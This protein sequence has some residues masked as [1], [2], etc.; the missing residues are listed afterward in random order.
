MLAELP[1]EPPWALDFLAGV[2]RGGWGCVLERTEMVSC[3]KELG[4]A[5]SDRDLGGLHWGLVLS[6][7]SHWA[8]LSPAAGMQGKL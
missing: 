5:A 1:L 3:W 4:C 2:C 6:R 7:P 8:T